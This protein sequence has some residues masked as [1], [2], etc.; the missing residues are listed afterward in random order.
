MREETF[1]QNRS[2]DEMLRTAKAVKYYVV[3]DELLNIPVVYM[4]K[5][6][7]DTKAI[8]YSPLQAVHDRTRLGSLSPTM[9][10]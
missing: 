4:S 6:I 7:M 10:S 3:E 8:Y 9:A 1:V 2:A 5:Y